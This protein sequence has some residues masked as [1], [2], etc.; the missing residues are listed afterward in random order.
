MTKLKPEARPVLIGSLPMADHRAA[1]ALVFK[2]TPDIPLWVQLPVYPQEGMIEQFLPGMPGFTKEGNKVFIDTTA[3]E[4]EQA[5]LSFYEEFLEVTEGRSGLANSRFAFI[6]ETGRGFAEF[7][8]QIDERESVPDGL[9]GQVTG[10]VTFG[11]A[12]KDQDGRAIFYNDQLR[13]A[14]CKHLAMNAAWQADQFSKRG[15]V[16]LIFIDEPGLAGFGTSELITITADDVKGAIGEITDAVHARG[17]L[18][19]VHVCANTQWDL[20]LGMDI[21]VISFDAYAYFDNFI[22]FSGEIKQYLDRG[23]SIAWGIVPTQDR[24]DIDRETVDSL[25][26]K[27]EKQMAVVEEKISVS[28]DRLLDQI[29]ITPSC[30]T[31]SLDMPHAQKVL[32][33][34]KALSDRIRK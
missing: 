30:G 10:P 22:L 20:L 28:R 26:E 21:D 8:N 2:Y 23:A 9:K 15:A 5:Y 32:A 18:A 17:G 29:F 27:F 31:G 13:D 24:D 19:G 12:V 33:L 7:L 11:T 25:E 34:T 16:P 3:A 4:F 6:P 1:T 14:A